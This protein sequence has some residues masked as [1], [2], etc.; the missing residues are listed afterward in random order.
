[1]RIASNGESVD[2]SILLPIKNA[3]VGFADVLESVMAQDMRC[4]VE[5]LAIDSGS[6]DGTREIAAHYPVTMHQIRPEEFGHGRTRNALAALAQGQVV[7]ML[8]Q[9]AKP[10]NRFRL[11]QLCAPLREP[12]VAATFGRQ[13]PGP[14]SSSRQRYFQQYWYPNLGAWRRTSSPA[15]AVSQSLFFSNVNAAYRKTAWEHIHFD[16]TLIMSED[17]QWARQALAAGYEL[18]YVPQAAVIHSHDYDLPSLFRRNF[19]S[20]ASLAGI[21][22]DK[23][24]DWF[25]L[26]FRYVAG[27][28]RFVR[29]T[30]GV[31]Q[32]PATLC[33][34]TARFLGFFCGSHHRVLPLVLKRR[35]SMHGYYW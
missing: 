19:D 18:V 11:A 9:D 16:E 32:V 14:G 22:S 12:Q 13:L 6:S 29:R 28:M 23:N 27:E 34:E 31:R 5:I 26:G 25:R 2:I 17:Q 1:M 7:V 21:T 15:S 35:F 24:A 10:A 20:G 30:D 3:G 4:N 33:H 8:T